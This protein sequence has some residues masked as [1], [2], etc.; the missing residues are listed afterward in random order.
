MTEQEKP[1]VN[2][3]EEEIKLIKATF[4]G[5]D[6]LLQL[7]R[8]V[9]LG[10]DLTEDEKEAVKSAYS[11]EPLMKIMY[12]R[13]LP[14][15]SKEEGIGQISD[16]WLGV[17]T[18]VFGHSKETIYQAIQYKKGAIELTQRALNLLQSPDSGDKIDVDYDPDRYMAD[19]LGVNLLIRNQYVR[20]VE[21]QLTFLKVISDFNDESKEDAQKRLKK[22]S[23]K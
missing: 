12:K 23:T 20:H 5:N 6:K 3:N 14:R 15:L 7:T 19:E 8:A 17:E 2:I 22:D 18:Q 13:F 21:N 4:K 10:L 1:K 16:T 11:S 9:M